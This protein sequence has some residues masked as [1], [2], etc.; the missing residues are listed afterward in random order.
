MGYSLIFPVLKFSLFHYYSQ[1]NIV[2]FHGSVDDYFK[3]TIA[4][5]SLSNNKGHY[6]IY[7]N[8]ICSLILYVAHI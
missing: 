3:V 5:P 7:L 6:C 8:K 2:L 4:I 1:E